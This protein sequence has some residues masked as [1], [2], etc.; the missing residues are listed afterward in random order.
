MEEPDFTPNESLRRIVCA[1]N[2]LV[3]SYYEIIMLIAPRHW[4]ATMYDQ[5]DQ[6]NCKYPPELFDQGFMDNFGKWHNRKDALVI[7]RRKNQII[8]EVGG[9]ETELYSEMLY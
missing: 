8:R 2:R 9:G 3:G 7:A 1:A 5:Y 4:D 6:M